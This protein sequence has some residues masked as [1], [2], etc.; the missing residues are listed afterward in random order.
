MDGASI[1]EMMSKIKKRF[2]IFATK[3]VE[4][5][6]GLS[7]CA[8]ICKTF[9]SLYWLGRLRF[10]L[11]RYAVKFEKIK[12]NKTCAVKF[13]SDKYKQALNP[14]HEKGNGY[15]TFGCIMEETGI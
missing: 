6:N 10:S 7:W 11:W 9:S 12:I 3:C 14:I 4:R 8:W 5:V 2:T 1:P 15:R 13:V